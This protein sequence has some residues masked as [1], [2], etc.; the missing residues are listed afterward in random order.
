M[1]SKITYCERRS[2][3]KQKI[4]SGIIVLPGNNESSMNYTDN[5]YAFRQDSTFLYF[6]GLQS[7]E[8]WGVI[9]VDTG[10][11]ILFGDDLSID[12]IVWMGSHPTMQDNAE[13][14]GIKKVKPLSE[15]SNFI[16]SA[17]GKGRE[18]HFLMPYRHDILLQLGDLM[19]VKPAQLES[20]VS[21]DLVRAVVAL[22]E[23]KSDEEIVEIEKAVNTSVDMHIAAI[24]MAAPGM[25]ESEIAAEIHRIALA[26]GGDIAFPIIATINGQTLHN[27]Y[28][29]NYLK[30][31]DLVLIDAG[32]QTEMGYCGDLSSTLPVANTFTETQ[33]MF[34]EIALRSH[35]KAISMLKPDVP[36]KEI[37]LASCRSIVDDMKS[38]GLMKGN[39]DDAVEQGAH[40]LFF[41]C[42]L[43]HMMGLDVHDMENLGE[44]WVGYNG[45]EKSTQF[46]IKSLRLAKELKPGY[47]IT[48]E[49]GV[50]F[51]PELIEL[52]KGQ[53]K[54]TDYL[55]Y[56]EIQKFKNFG[57]IR[58]EEDFLI[59]EGGARLLGKPCPKTIE[60]VENLRK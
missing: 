2:N 22:R 50:Y 26:S 27:H 55:N 58:N 40:A 32:A 25:K 17:K 45:L 14:A 39:T 24:K 59:T 33:K 23:L 6:F 54:L 60:Q 41:P 57:G 29:G 42:G 56:S 20:M 3:L 10:E 52:W 31:G 11:E 16:A 19:D 53:N 5:T 51:I 48:I 44:K 15:L 1:F 38:I 8:L 12:M 37:Y 28:H 18:I 30:K 43:G 13:R 49:P 21:E 46:G 36:F 35:E 34:Y 47:V 9:D 7:P 4:N